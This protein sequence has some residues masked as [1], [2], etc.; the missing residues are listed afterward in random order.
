MDCPAC[1]HTNSAT[2]KFCE[3]CA[4]PMVRKCSS[5]GTELSATAK[6]CAECGTPAGGEPAPVRAPAAPAAASPASYTPRHLADKIIN[7]RS[8]VEGERKLVTVLFADLKGSMELVADRDPEEAQRFLDPAI[9]LMMEA[10]H[11][12]EGTVSLVLGDG[13][14][15]IFGAPVAHE[16]HAVRA[17]YAALKIQE[18]AARLSEELRAKHGVELNVRVG[19]NSGD[20]VVRSVGSDL[21][22]D[23]SAIGHTTHLASRLEQLAEPGS[24]LIGP[25]TMRL[26]EGYVVARPGGRKA[27][28][29]LAQALEV[30]ELLGA[31]PVRSRLHAA[32][33]RGLTTLMG[34]ETEL[35]LMA[36]A[37]QRAKHDHGQVMAV[38]GEAGIGKSRLIWEFVRCEAARDCLVLEGAPAVY[39][40][41]TSY[42]PIIDLLRGYL[43]IEK[44]ETPE[45]IRE[46]VA[47]KLVALDRSFASF[48]P[49]LLFLLGVDKEDPEWLKLDP[50]VRQSRLQL[51]LRNL[52]VVESRRQPLILM[53]D[54]LHWI[55]E[56]TQALLDDLVDHVASSRMLLLFGYRPEYR[57][58]WSRNAMFRE[59]RIAPLPIAGAKDLLDLMLG[60]DRSLRP[61]KAM[62]IERTDGNPFFIEES[63]RSLVEMKFIGGGPGTFRLLKAADTVRIPQS[64]KSVLS[65]RIDRLSGTDKR[66][67]QAAAVI[68]KEV[69]FLLLKQ[70]ADATDDELRDALDQLKTLEF[71]YET[72]L[73]P[74]L[75]YTFRHALVQEVSYDSLLAER[76]LTL[77]RAIVEAYEASNV[78]PTLEALDRLA[79]HS[80][81][82]EMWHKAVDYSRRAGQL[83]TREGAFKEAT[84]YFANALKNVGR[85]DGGIATDGLGVDIRFDLR[86]PQMLLGQLDDAKANLLEALAV[87]R[88]TQDAPRLGLTQC[89]LCNVYWEL[90]EQHLAIE[91]GEEARTVGREIG[92]EKI[93][94]TARRYVARAYQSV[95]QYR[96]AVEDYRAS[97]PE[98][99]GRSP[100]HILI[101]AFL[102]TCMSEMGDFEEAFA[103]GHETI[104]LAEADG[105]PLSHSAALSAMGRAHVRAGR[106]EEAV[107]FSEKAL[108]I[109]Q[110]AGIALLYPF[111]AAPLGVAYAR[112]GRKK[113]ALELLETSIERADAMRR[114]VD[115]SLWRYWQAQARFITGDAAGARQAAERGLALSITYKE[116]G[117]QAGLLRV[118]GDIHTRVD[119]GPQKAEP[120]FMQAIEIAGELEMRP[121]LARCHF[122]L[123]Q[124]Y[125]KNG[126]PEKAA[127]ARRT[128]QG[129]FGGIETT[130]WMNNAEPGQGASA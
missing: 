11:N 34:R 46:K 19:I 98:D 94:D 76:R 36:Q 105:T 47:Q 52:F 40:K 96:R 55:D 99:G 117:N 26:V 59:V 29:G 50:Q 72:S 130:F 88:R 7:S 41:S 95:G 54:D 75:R 67:L 22:M 14:M 27:V 49:G 79:H 102:L 73:F 42:G 61:I 107:P 43:E 121:L 106:F 4:T 120:Y 92:D 38:S 81:H 122:G 123:S 68:G 90:G 37:L 20:V 70:I 12:Y 119:D 91:A 118:L 57:H 18:A 113:E 103:F 97:L 44:M 32:A 48:L 53:I 39:G 124:L 114:M 85:V 109:S 5:C 56:E 3:Q 63:I 127:E 6:F 31:T 51:G 128:A 15:A 82:A 110:E 28:K 10:V 45:E 35:E 111:G 64:A 1:A 104:R 125:D 108:A 21:R 33:E 17:C 112:I 2:A 13:L 100:S 115:A 25:A 87:A 86:T 77:H 69:P 30:F 58:D 66:V 78:E 62:L 89:F 129:I 74:E 8:A 65:A 60:Q 24:T 116:R 101:R 23:Y 93:A 71:L 80:Y 16:D 83:A 9:N 126:A 84:N